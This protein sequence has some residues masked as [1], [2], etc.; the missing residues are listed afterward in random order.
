MTGDITEKDAMK[1]ALQKLLTNNF[2]SKCSWTG[3]KI[4]FKRFE[5]NYV[6]EK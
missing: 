2:A 3:A 5:H 6:H 4:N 1:R